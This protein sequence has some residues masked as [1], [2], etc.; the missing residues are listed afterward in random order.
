MTFRCLIPIAILLV[1][2]CTKPSAPP[3]TGVGGAPA[4]TLETPPK[5]DTGP[6]AG[7][8]ANDFL[9]ALHDGKATAGQLTPT[10]KKVIAEPV[11]DADRV[12]GYS[13]SAAENWLKQ[14]Q[15]KLGGFSLSSPRID[16]VALYTGTVKAEKPLHLLLRLVRHE[17]RWT[18]DWLSLS[19]VAIDTATA[20][21]PQSFAASAYLQALLGHRY[22]LAAGAMTT[23]LKKSLAPALGSESRLYNAGILKTKLDGYRG[24][25]TGY[26]LA[27]A[28]DGTASGELI[29]AAGKKPFALKLVAGERP[30]E[31]LVDE[32]KVD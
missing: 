2:G 23:G 20:V 1:V 17:N 11:F 9:S 7:R 5:T 32:I 10:F 4:V 12:H 3:A 16:A 6:K 24:P 21:T 18:V 29:H 31:W 19:E 28:E 14:F 22:D 27:Q 15:G 26:A 30:N 13:D 25:A 8:F